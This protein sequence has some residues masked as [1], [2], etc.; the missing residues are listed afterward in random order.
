MTEF[1]NDH[2]SFLSDYIDRHPYLLD[3]YVMESV[4]ED[5]VKE[6]LEKVSDPPPGTNFY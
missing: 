5:T 1:L 2:P 3:N 6:W 4:E